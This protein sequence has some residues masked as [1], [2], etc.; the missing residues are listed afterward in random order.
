MRLLAVLLFVCG[1][2]ATPQWHELARYSFEEYSRDFSRMYASAEEGAS[3]RAIF[4]R[5]LADILLHNANPSTTWKKGVNHF[6]DRTEQE[7]SSLRGYDKHL[8]FLQKEKR[9][10]RP[11]HQQ[12]NEAIE[13]LSHVNIDDLPSY[14]DWREQGVVTP[15]KDQGRCGSCWTFGSTE[16]LESHYAIK[17]GV[18]VELSEQAILDCVPNPQSCG[19]S[20]GCGGGTVELAYDTILSKGWKGMPS[21]WTYPYKSHEAQA[22]SCAYNASTI[23]PVAASFSGYVSL[24]TNQYDPVMKALATIG[25]LAINVDAS[26]W[27]SYENGVYSGCNLTSPDINHV[28]LLV[29]Y[30][31]DPQFGDYWLLRNSWTPVWGEKGYMRLARSSNVTC[32][33]DVVPED[34]TGCS[35]SPPQT[36]CGPCGVL[37]DALY[38]VV[39]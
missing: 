14:V 23:V 39:A 34:G 12:A 37:F 9:T 32:G 28:V 26:G 21:E 38:P 17:K 3:R 18:L 15:V 11:F 16:M 10:L 33:I 6:T 29:G 1:I 8:G 19:G 31:T 4:E 13:Q 22:Y 2:L 30:G 25:P 5:R 36:V 27:H 35:G 20:G 7:L 24:P